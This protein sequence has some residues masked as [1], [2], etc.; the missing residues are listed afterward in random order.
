VIVIF[1]ELS[2]NVLL[3]ISFYFKVF[4]VFYVFDGLIFREL[5][6]QFI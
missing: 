2:E 4:C 3:F 6:I 5:E 1:S